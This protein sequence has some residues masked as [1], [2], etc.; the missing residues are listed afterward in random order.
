MNT[1]M[2][3]SAAIDMNSVTHN[4]NLDNNMEK[5]NEKIN[6]KINNTTNIKND[7]NINN[8]FD[9]SSYDEKQHSL[10]LDNQVDDSPK[11]FSEDTDVSFNDDISDNYDESIKKH[12]SESNNEIDKDLS[13]LSFDDKDDL[14]IPAFLRR[15]TN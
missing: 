6:G 11:L 10:D 5:E 15:Q 8:F 3:G 14:E 12:E 7:R 13:D 4:S 1:V 2:S 9:D